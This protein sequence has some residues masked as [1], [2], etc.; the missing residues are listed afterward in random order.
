MLAI[1]PLLPF[2]PDYLSFLIYGLVTGGVLR[3]WSIAKRHVVLMLLYLAPCLFWL[4]VMWAF[5]NVQPHERQIW[6]LVGVVV[7]FMK[8][9]AMLYVLFAFIFERVMERIQEARQDR[10]EQQW[11]EPPPQGNQ[12]YQRGWSNADILAE[13]ARREAEAKAHRSRQ[14]GQSGFHSEPPPQDKIKDKS[15]DKPQEPP[16]PPQSSPENRSYEQVLGLPLGWTQEDLKNA[17]KRESQRTHP[18]KWIGKPEQIRQVMEAEFKAIQK[19]YDKL[20]K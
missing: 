15:R 6:F 20:K 2:F 7:T 8:P 18:D 11:R 12:G 10:R 16:K 19:A 13:Q 1:N 5:I 14:Q 17:Y 4:V 9:F 3:F